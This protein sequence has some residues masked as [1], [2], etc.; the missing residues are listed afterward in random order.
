MKKKINM[1]KKN[2]NKK[3]PYILNSLNFKYKNNNITQIDSNNRF[4][5]LFGNSIKNLKTSCS[6]NNNGYKKKSKNNLSEKHLALINLESNERRENLS[7][8]LADNTPKIPYHRYNNN[9]FDK[10]MNYNLLF[11]KA[12]VFIIKLN[13]TF[14]LD[15]LRLIN[16]IKTTTTKSFEIISKGSVIE[17]KA[18]SLGL[19]TKGG[20]LITKIRA[21]VTNNPFSDGCVNSIALNDLDF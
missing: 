8:I 6:I 5:F 4:P 7:K 12:N 11:K 16:L 1:K 17:A 14:S 13:K 3:K 15:L 19:I 10:K 21:K 9:C 2:L 20:I 18:S